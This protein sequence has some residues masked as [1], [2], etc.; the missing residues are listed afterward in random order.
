MV[1]SPT[2][3][4]IAQGEKLETEQNLA[5]LR[6]QTGSTAAAKAAAAQLQAIINQYNASGAFPPS[7]RSSPTSR[8][9]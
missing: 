1:A 6:A 8:P 5:L 2:F 4:L 3:F 7:T 9:R